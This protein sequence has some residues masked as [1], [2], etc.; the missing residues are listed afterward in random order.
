MKGP[1]PALFYRAAWTD[2]WAF[3]KENFSVAL[4]TAFYFILAIVVSNGC[5]FM[6]GWCETMPP[7]VFWLAVNL[8][9]QLA[10]LG[11]PW[12]LVIETVRTTVGRKSD[13][14]RIHFDAFLCMALGI[15]LILWSIVFCWFPFAFLMY[16]LAMIHMAMPVTKRGWINFAMFSRAFFKNFG[17]TVYFWVIWL[18]L[19]IMITIPTA[20]LAAL[21]AV[22]FGS[23]ITGFMQNV[24]AQKMPA[25]AAEWIIAVLFVVVTIVFSIFYGMAEV[26]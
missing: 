13:I 22:A 6:V 23:K 26:F 11:W 3:L 5:G 7:K 1:D 12:H 20:I 10:W 15:K 18:A 19:N 14:R 16:P 24:A 21:V 25:G 2:S 8:A 17:P 4:R 9:A